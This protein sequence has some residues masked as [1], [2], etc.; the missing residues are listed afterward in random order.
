MNK[1]L[2]TFAYKLIYIFRINDSTHSGLL[3][4]GEAT[5]VTSKP[6]E[7]LTPNCKD[8]NIAAKN[9]I[10]QYTTTAGIAYELLYT[11]LAIHTITKKGKSEVK[12]FSDHDVHKVLERS[13]IKR[14]FF[15]T[16]QKANEWFKTDLETAKKAILA[17]KQCRSSLYQNEITDEHNPIT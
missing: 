7:E 12:A 8:L 1:F 17:V 11:E 10:N 3:K 16:Q 2:S 4:I 9:R 5:C 13:N 15:D 6:I 14:H